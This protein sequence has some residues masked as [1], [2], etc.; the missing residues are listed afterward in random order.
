VDSLYE[1]E[2]NMDVLQG[3]VSNGNY[4]YAAWK[5]E[6][7]D[8]R[9][10][11]SRWSGGSDK[12]M[13]AA[14]MGNGTVAG[15]SSVGP[16]LGS[17]SGT[18]L[19][20]AWKGEYS[21]PR[22]FFAKYE[23]SNWQALKPI[24][25]V[26][27]HVGPALCGFGPNLIAAWKNVFDQNLYFATYDGRHW[28]A[29]LPIPG[30]AS[31]VG[32]S[33]ATY[34]QNQKLYAVWKG[35]GADQSLWYAM[36]DGHKW[37]GQTAGSSQTQIPGVGSSKGASLATVGSKLYAVWKGE[38]TDQS[39]YYA[40]YDGNKWSGETAESSQT[41]IPGI[42]S[43]VGAA[44]AEFK[45][46]LYAMCK[47]RDSDVTLYNAEL[48]GG[49][50]P[51]W[52]S[53][54]PG[55]TGPDTHTTLVQ[56]P[57]GGNLNYLL[58]DSKGAALTGTT[59]TIIVA[60][61]I[62]P[63]NAGAYSFQINCRGPAPPS[64]AQ[65]FGWQQYGFRIARSQLFFWVN[66][67]QQDT[68]SSQQFINW[69]SRSLPND[70]GVLGLVNNRLPKGL[71]LTTTLETDHNSNVTGFAF[72]I[73]NAGRTVLESPAR[74]LLSIDPSVVP[75]NLSSILNLQV[76]LV[77]ENKFD[78]GSADTVNFSA[79]KGIFHCFASNNLTAS[80]SQDESAEGSNISYS[81]LPASYP[82]GEFYQPFGIGLS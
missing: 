37:S 82:N 20:A 29:P 31:S 49:T 81:S 39:L 10:F 36:Y 42:G 18:T 9:L 34:G 66:T 30:V 40:Q 41:Q 32:P 60:D 13:P 4:L 67:F 19:Y 17:V 2:A 53:D 3:L 43:S 11:Y 26:Y 79:G 69:D 75:G 12:W 22:L 73:A 44:I 48:N 50:P 23:G 74:T 7:N 33:L 15:N 64:G 59:V 78:D 25:N 45:G 5:G 51:V 68:S 24:P 72:S 80:V 28:S 76:I 21:D 14:P 54:I 70:T 8:D 27:S 61:D 38:G 71:Q 62:V 35:E 77:A 58:A 46:K 1:G 47:G 55:D 65:T 63:D 52:T 16:S 56:A 6:P 57:A